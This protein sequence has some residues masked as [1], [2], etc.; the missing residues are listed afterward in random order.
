MGEIAF[1]LFMAVFFICVFLDGLGGHGKKTV[2]SRGVR[3][4][5]DKTPFLDAFGRI[6]IIAVIIYFIVLLLLN[7]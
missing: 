1:F 3:Y 2:S 6:V 5:V 4:R 7:N